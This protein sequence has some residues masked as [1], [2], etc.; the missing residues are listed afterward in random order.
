MILYVDCRG[1][2]LNPADLRANRMNPELPL[3]RSDELAM[4]HRLHDEVSP[5]KKKRQTLRL[6]QANVGKTPPAHDG[7]LASANSE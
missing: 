3:L 6:F 5:S 4:Q 2:A 1:V 7:A